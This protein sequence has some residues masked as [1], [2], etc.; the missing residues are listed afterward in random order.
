MIVIN[1]IHDLIDIIKD[2][3]DHNVRVMV[4]RYG[5]TVYLDDDPEDEGFEKFLIPI[6][7]DTYLDCACISYSELMK[8]MHEPNED[9]AIEYDEIILIHKIMDYLENNKSEIDKICDN[10][11]VSRYKSNNSKVTS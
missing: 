4:D 1:L 10:L 6:R 8:Y 3:S 11:S 7:Y 2:D 9:V 5:V